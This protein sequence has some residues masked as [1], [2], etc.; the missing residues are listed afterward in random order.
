MFSESMNPLGLQCQY[1]RKQW[2]YFEGI[3]GRF[4]FVYIKHLPTH[5]L[6]SKNRCLQINQSVLPIKV[7][8]L[9]HNN[10]CH[11]YTAPITTFYKQICCLP[12][13]SSN[14][15]KNQKVKTILQTAVVWYQN[16]PNNCY[17]FNKKQQPKF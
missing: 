3:W 8:K 17:V 7:D 14:I 5:E 12:L 9:H 4:P 15:P 16:D 6:W 1:R 13:K 11:V 2:K 10:F